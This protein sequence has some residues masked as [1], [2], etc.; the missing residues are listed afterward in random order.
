[1]GKAHSARLVSGAVLLGLALA[2]GVCA[3]RAQATEQPAARAVEDP[4][5][6][7]MLDQAVKTDD[8][9]IKR[10]IY[11]DEI[12]EKDQA[13]AE[14]RAEARQ[15][16]KE[17]MAAVAQ[18]RVAAEE[19]KRKKDKK[20]ED[21]ARGRAALSAAR[22]AYYSSPPNLSLAL[23]KLNAAKSLG[24]S[25]PDLDS[26]EKD[27]GQRI[28]RRTLGRAVGF[29]C[30]MAALTGLILWIVFL[31]RKKQPYIEVLTGPDRGRRHPIEKDIVTIGAL[32][33]KGEE[34]NDIV[35]SD[36]EKTIS[37]F[38]CEI[39]RKGR[40][41]YL[42]DCNSANGTRLDGRAI[43]PGRLV[44]LKRGARIRLGAD[45]ELKFGLERR[46]A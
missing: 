22:S 34:K 4:E 46:K 25:G 23:Q 8:P 12:L 41:V 27:L 37:R 43:P 45:C 1:M 20:R 35:V 32:A 15:G 7:R 11:C 38:H 19:E 6:T 2:A 18:K 17:A 14:H 29:G 13:S 30:G 21:D 5:V 3:A 36:R 16:C 9:E 28:W 39:H 40:K 26:L 44:P 33:Q 42:V 10:K 31:F 24:Q